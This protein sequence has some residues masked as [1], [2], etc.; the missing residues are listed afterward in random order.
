MK[1]INRS[2]SKY[3][4]I[5][6]NELPFFL[7][8][9]NDNIKII[10][11]SFLNHNI[12]II[13]LI[14]FLVFQ[15]PLGITLIQVE[16]T[17][18]IRVEETTD[19]DNINQ[20]MKEHDT[21]TVFRLSEVELTNSQREQ[22]VDGYPVSV[23]VSTELATDKAL[24]L[25]DSKLYVTNDSISSLERMSNKYDIAGSILSVLLMISIAIGDLL[26]VLLFSCSCLVT[27]QCVFVF[28]RNP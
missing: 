9:L 2:N 14:S 4:W 19:R 11:L 28:M 17:E 5:D 20:A 21:D 12:T 10:L 16:P 7:S 25:D 23:P 27:V 15:L 6:K 3:N 1:Y 13:L 24:I 26:W 18:D 8:F 22:F